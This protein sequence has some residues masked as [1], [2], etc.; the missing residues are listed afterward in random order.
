MKEI[1]ILFSTLMVEAELELRKTN[2]RR[3]RGLEKI[4]KNPE[5]WSLLGLDIDNTVYELHKKAK[6]LPG[7]SACFFNKAS[8]STQ[9]VKCPFGQKGDL[10]WVRETWCLPGLYDGGEKDYYFKA[11]FNP[12]SLENKNASESWRPSIHM[13]K[14]AARIWLQVEEIRVERLHDISEEDILNEGILIPVSEKNT[15]CFILGVENSAFSFLPNGCLA[16]GATPPTKKQILFAFWAELW[17]KINGRKSWDSNPWVWVVKFKVLSTT[18]K[19]QICYKT[20]EVC[21]YDCKGLCRE[22]M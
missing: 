19:P 17:C 2:T 4:N 8:N 18:G 21:K 15:P 11:G 7:L 22:S 6:F 20:N 14:D 16:D 1:P 12:A 10:L 9:F 5:S 13:P 3:T